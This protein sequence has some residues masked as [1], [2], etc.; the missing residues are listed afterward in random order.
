MRRLRLSVCL[1]VLSALAAACRP[2]EPWQ[3][4]AGSR[5]NIV[6][7][8]LCSF[9]AD[10]LGASGY[11]RGL[12]PFLDRLAG[13]GVFFENAVS[14][15]S[16]TKPSAAS[17]LTGLTPNV[18]QMLDFYPLDAIREER[19]TP[20]RVLP[21]GF[22]TLPEAL[23]AAGYVTFCRVNNV[24]AGGFFNLTQGCQDAVTRHGLRL[25]RMVDELAVWLGSRPQNEPRQP[26][27]AYLFARDVHTP[28]NPPY[29][30][31]RRLHSG[32]DLPPPDAYPAWR[33]EV[34]RQVRQ[35]VKAGE[36]VPEALRRAWIDLY[37]AQ[38]PAVDAALA[39]LP[40]LLEEAGVGG[41]TLIVVTADHGDRFFDHGL[42]GHGG[43]L[44]EAVL[45]IP[46]LAAGPGLAAGRRVPQVVR[47]IDF[48]PTL[49]Q[50]A[51]ARLPQVLQ[52][53]S[54]LPLLYSPTADLPAASA[55]SSFGGVAHTVR[56]GRHKLYRGP[57]ERRG[58]YDLQA[59]PGEERDLL[60][61]E[62]ATARL[63]AREL[64]AWLEQEEALARVVEQAGT[65][66]LPPEV[67]EELRTLG[68]L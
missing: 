13:Q 14:A 5:P 26:F 46:L 30:A 31:L 53:R 7:V 35:R 27:F 28:Y 49:A 62:P 1:I 10:H 56:L 66:E 68:Y 64:A 44:D 24:H 15:S 4:A 58:L 19:I 3:Q 2:P 20:K 8:V 45:K 36:A 55:F 65:R 38:L 40:S 6:L 21:D 25:P 37:D 63:L 48:Y 67:L 51:G 57:G 47:S 12:T 23:A 29:E 43:L 54:L 41:E 18:H 11:P 61:A 16:W 17:L 34:D 42:I 9:S 59:D 22:E 39:R 33:Q 60:A 50:V 32:G 52:G